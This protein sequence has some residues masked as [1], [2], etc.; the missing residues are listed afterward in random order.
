M[1]IARLLFSNYYCESL[2]A[3]TRENNFCLET[4]FGKEFLISLLLFYKTRFSLITSVT[5]FPLH[6]WYRD[7]ERKYPVP[8]RRIILALER[9]TYFS[10]TEF[11]ITSDNFRQFL[12]YVSLGENGAHQG[13][14]PFVGH[15]VRLDS[16]PHR[17][18]YSRTDDL[19]LWE[20]RIH[21]QY[22]VH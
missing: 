18:S 22:F 14:K 10:A 17:I 15:E 2:S 3:L 1:K 7:L 4:C 12:T 6:A 13:T 20:I 21:K 9:R 11:V 19:Q 8:D 5:F 16:I